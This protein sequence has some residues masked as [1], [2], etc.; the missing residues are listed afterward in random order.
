[1]KKVLESHPNLE[2][3]LLHN[4]DTLGASLNLAALGHHLEA[5]NNLTFEVIPRRIEDRGGGLARING[6][7]RI[8]E[9]L[10]QPREEDELNLSYY[11]SMSTWIQIEDILKLFG[12]TWYII[13]CVC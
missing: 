11:N 9:G 8:L 1:M 13:V 10:A 4:I 3:L 7:V 12:R 6:K 2:T 5:G